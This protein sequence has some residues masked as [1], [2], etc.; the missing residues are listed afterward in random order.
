MGDKALMEGSKVV[1][2]D[3]PVPHSPIRE[4]PNKA[5][6][7]FQLGPIYPVFCLH[8]HCQ[9]C[10]NQVKAPNLNRVSPT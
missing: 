5:D 8:W 3:P 6:I 4:N 10:L 7:K 1:M 2:G 9:D